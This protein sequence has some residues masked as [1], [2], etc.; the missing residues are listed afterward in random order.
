MSGEYASSFDEVKTYGGS[1]STSRT[2]EQTDTVTSATDPTF[3]Q[4]SR[5]LRGIANTAQLD[6]ADSAR[7]FALVHVAAADTMIACFEAKYYYNFWRPNH[8]IQRAD[9]DGNHKTRPDPTWSHLVAAEPPRVS[10]R[11]QLLHRCLRRGPADVLPYGPAAA[12][13][14]E[15]EVCGR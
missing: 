2:Q 7:L 3:V 1:A 4:W 8:A 14:R 10:V 12:L 15:H 5:T 13:D 6:L 11:P 9:T